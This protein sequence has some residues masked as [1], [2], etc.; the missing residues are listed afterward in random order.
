MY[1]TVRDAGV[2]DTM[3]ADLTVKLPIGTPAER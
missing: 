3:I 2:Q 1:P